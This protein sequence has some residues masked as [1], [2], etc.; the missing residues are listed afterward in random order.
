MAYP[1]N[2]FKTTHLNHLGLV[3]GMFDEL[4]IGETLNQAIPQDLNKRN[5]SIG[6][7]V[8]AMVLNGLGFVNQTLYLTPQFFEKIPIDKLLGPNIKAD[9]L[10]DNVLGRC[11]DTLF[12][13]DL[14]LLYCKISM[15]ALNQ[16]GLNRGVKMHLDSS[17]FHVHG[18][19]SDEPEIGAINITHGFSKDHRPDLKQAVLNLITENRAGIPLLMV[20]ADGN[21]QDKKGFREII[22]KH[23][24]QMQ[25]AQLDYLVSDS[26]LYSSESLKQ[27]KQNQMNWITR[28]PETSLDVKWVLDHIDPALLQPMKPGYRYFVLGNQYADV[29]QRWLIIHSESKQLRSE[30]S[31]VKHFLKG[32]QADYKLFE[33]LKKKPFA[34]E[35]DARA[36]YIETQNQ[37]K[38]GY[39]EDFHISNK[40]EYSK[41]GRPT[42]SSQIKG[43]KYFVEG[44]I[45]FNPEDYKNYVFKKGYFIL[46]T[47]QCDEKKLSDLECFELYKDQNRTVERGF[48]FLKD[49]MFMLDNLF[50]KKPRRIMALMMIMTLCLM[51]YAAVEFRIRQSM[52]AQ[53]AKFPNQ[54]GKMIDNPTARWVF[55]YFIGIDILIFPDGKT[56]IINMDPH[57]LMIIG[58]LG[59]AYEYYYS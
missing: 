11:L 9:M 31:A 49:P 16:L 18:Q 6:E 22:D 25:S 57:H 33:K 59:A 8:K 27:Y 19:Y 37:L 43:Q 4:K 52:K 17:S 26:A 10:D 56:Q 1:I 46:A 2:G 34:C 36:A 58:L 39:V 5:V 12:K 32:T 28:V 23:I 40:A 41:S 45:Y 15:I 13:N 30:N 44:R 29:Q 14:E 42:K 55:F 48:R 51:V 50:L 21:S 7:A 35:Q 53:S 24:Q 47:N 38:Y 3:A 54:Q 20:P